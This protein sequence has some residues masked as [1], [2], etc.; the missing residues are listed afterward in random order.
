M[1]GSHTSII[2]GSIM[3]AIYLFV[4]SEIMFFS[5]FFSAIFY[6][7]YAGEVNDYNLHGL[8]LL[9]PFRVP[10]LNTILLLSSRVLCTL[11]HESVLF[12]E[13]DLNNLLARLILRLMFF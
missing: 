8:N 1:L 2:S 3:V 6:N 9:D 12:G 11:V 5:G 13:L 7:F 10:L 4:F